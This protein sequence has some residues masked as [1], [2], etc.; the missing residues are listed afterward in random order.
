ME[1]VDVA[2]L[3]VQLRTSRPR[4]ESDMRKTNTREAPWT[5]MKATH[6]PTIPQIYGCT[7]EPENG[8]WN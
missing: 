2:A 5:D 1:T 4:R 8:L 3:V 6:R 7:A